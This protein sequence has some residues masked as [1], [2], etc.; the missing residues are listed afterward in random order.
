MNDCDQR[1]KMARIEKGDLDW[2]QKFLTHVT[3]ARFAIDVI[4]VV[5][6]CILRDRNADSSA[7]NVYGVPARSSPANGG[8]RSRAK[9]Q[10][11]LI[12]WAAGLALDERPLSGEA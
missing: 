5:F 8:M 7:G 1:M 11:M 12:F 6:G 3:C 2:I 10:R 9:P 4:G